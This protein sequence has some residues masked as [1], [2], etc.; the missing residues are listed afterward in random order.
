MIEFIGRVPGL[1]ARMDVLDAMDLSRQILDWRNRQNPHPCPPPT[2]LVANQI[3]G[4]LDGRH[5]PS[6]ARRGDGKRHAILALHSNTQLLVWF[7][8][9]V[10]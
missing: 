4:A 7:G 6:G 8:T 9:V 2:P 1:V 10:T 3:S 5:A